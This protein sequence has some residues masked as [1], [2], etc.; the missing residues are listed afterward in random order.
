MAALASAQPTDPRL[1][2]AS[3]AQIRQDFSAPVAAIVGYIEL[4][5]ED[6][7]RCG[8]ERLAPDVAR[9][10]RASLALHQLVE[11][12]LDES[13]TARRAEEASGGPGGKLRHDLRTPLNAIKRYA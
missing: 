8:L 13:E 4:L 7:P 6:I 3:L 9:M 10:H 1:D 11:E 5:A 2:A 12:V